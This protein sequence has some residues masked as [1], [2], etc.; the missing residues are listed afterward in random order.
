MVRPTICSN[1]LLWQRWKAAE[2]Y[3][4]NYK[5]LGY[6]SFHDHLEKKIG[7][8]YPP[9]IISVATALGHVFIK[10]VLWKMSNMSNSQSW[11]RWVVPENLA[12]PS[13]EGLLTRQ[14]LRLTESDAVNDR[15]HLSFSLSSLP[16]PSRTMNE[17]NLGESFGQFETDFLILCNQS[18]WCLRQ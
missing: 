13:Q 17:N 15:W 16:A 12:I 7:V 14:V 5:Y 8:V 4:Y 11:E 6:V 2:V 1:K 9:P 10:S 18:T 3:W